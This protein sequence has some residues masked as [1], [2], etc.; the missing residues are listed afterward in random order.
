MEPISEIVGILHPAYQEFNIE[1][2][3]IWTFQEIFTGLLP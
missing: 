1:E 3:M 2:F